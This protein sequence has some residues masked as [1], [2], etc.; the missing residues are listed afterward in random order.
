MYVFIIV[1]RV[2][3]WPV[4]GPVING[5]TFH[6]EINICRPLNYSSPVQ[7]KG[8]PKSSVCLVSDSSAVSYG[9][10]IEIENTSSY[11]IAAN[12]GTGFSLYVL[13][14]TLCKKDNEK[15]EKYRSHINFVCGPHLGAPELIL[16]N[17]CQVNFLWRTSAACAVKPT[18]QVP[19][20]VLD[21]NGNKRDLSPLIKKNE[22]YSV[23]TPN[24]AIDFIINVCSDI[25]ENS[26]ENK[27]PKNA[28]ACR[29]SG[30]ESYSFGSV[31]GGLKYTSEGLV[32]VYKTPDSAI[33]SPNCSLKPKTTI[34]FKCPARGY[35]QPPKLISDSNCQYE[36]E[37][38]TEYACPENLLKGNLKKC[39]F[40]RELHG[41]EID[42][43]PLREKHM[44]NV[45]VPGTSEYFLLSVCSGLEEGFKCGSKAWK[46][47]SVCF[48]NSNGSLQTA[49][50]T[51][52]AK[53]LYADG[54]VV[55]TYLKGESCNGTE[56]ST[57][58]NF[59][60]DK[61]A[62]NNGTGE[63]QHIASNDCSHIFEW[64]T[65]H[66]CL[67]HPLDA[68]CYVTFDK[69]TIDL[70]KKML[71]QGEPWEA[72][73]LRVLQPRSR[74]EYFIN[75]CGPIFNL[76]NFSMCGEGSSA[77]VLKDTGT[78]LNLGNFTSPPVYD[79]MSNSVWLH[80]TGG[81]PCG[82]NKFWHSSINFIC[83]PGQISSELILTR[84]NEVE[85]HYEFEWETADACP[86]TGFIEGSECR[87]I[88]N[89]FGINYDLNPLKSKVYKVTSPLYE[90]YLGVCEPVKDS[91]C[92]SKNVGVCQV[93]RSNK[94]AWKAGEPTSH[95]SYMDGV[96]NLMYMS[97]DP[98]YDQNHTSR[99]T[100]I[101]F[102]CDISAGNGNPH[103]IEEDDFAFVFH[104]Y[105]SLVCPQRV[106]TECIVHD[107]F[108]DVMYA[109]SDLSMPKKNWVTT[110]NEDNK[111][112]QIY[113]NV[114]RSLVLPTIGC[115]PNAAACLTEQ[116]ENGE[117]KVVV[118]NL[119][120][121]VNPPVLQSPGHL[122]LTYTD[123]DPCVSYGV[124]TTYRT[125]IHFLCADKDTLQTSFRFLSKVGACE[126]SF[127]W[128]TKAACPYGMASKDSCQLTDPDSGFTFDIMPLHQ[129]K[130]PYSIPSPSGGSFQL[131][132]CGKVTNG[133]FAS[134]GSQNETDKNVSV[135]EVDSKG[136]LLSN[137][138]TSDSFVLSYASKRELTL[139][140]KSA[141]GVS[142]EE[143]TIQFPCVN[144]TSLSDPKL[145]HAESGH[146]VFELKTP[147]ACI[148][149]PFDCNVVDGFGH[150]YDFTP[151][152]KYTGGN[153]EV[154]DF[155]PE[156][157]QLKYHINFC[158]PLNKVKSYKC[159]G[160]TSSACQTTYNNSEIIGYDLGS[161][162]V[163]PM[164]GSNGA[165]VFQYTD[166][167]YCLGGKLKR[168][169]TINLFCS[170]E[171]GDLKFLEET[172]ECEYIF[173]LDTPAAC[174]LQSSYGKNCI[175]KEPTFG[176][177]FNLNPLKNKNNNY[178]VTIG[179]YNYIFNVCDKI[180]GFSNKC[181]NSS[182]CQLKTKDPSFSKSLGLPSDALIY[183]KGVI[184]LEYKSGSS[185]CHGKYNR[186]TKIT[187]TCHHAHEDTDGPI[188]IAEAEDCTYLF[189]WP[190]VH[191][192]PPFDV[193][194]C[195]A[196][197][198]NG[199][200]YDL[201]RLSLPNENYY[202]KYPSA[203]KTF[204]INVCRSVVHTPNSLCPY[205]S[206]AC[207]ID[208]SSKLEPINL[209]TV[210]HAPYFDSGKIKI[211]YTSGDPCDEED[212]HSARFMQT[213]IEFS[214]DPS[215]I[216]SGPE[217]IGKDSC[218][219]Y[220]DW[221]TAYACPPK[222]IE[223]KDDCTV[224]DPITGYLFNF[225]SLG[226]HGVF[227]HTN[228][229]HQ[230]FLNV[231]GNDGTSPCGATVG[232]CQEEILGEKR[233]WSG[234]KLNRNLIYNNGVLLLNYTNGDSCHG[235]QFQ[236]N[237]LIEIH[238]GQGINE[239][240]FL[241]ESHNCTYVFSWKTELACQNHRHCAI[242]NGS[243]YYDL[244]PL[245]ESHHIAASAIINDNASYYI[246]VCNS[247]E[248]IAGVYCPPG[249]AI[250]RISRD[251]ATSSNIA[252]VSLFYYYCN[253]IVNV[254]S[255][256]LLS[257]MKC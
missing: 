60:C 247:L 7:Q 83:K 159:P 183:R 74:A 206:A 251:S 140:Y 179:E 41:A 181:A 160:G 147:L 46:S 51:N 19:C 35:S 110:I 68:P 52:S 248:E 209:G 256:K 192:C 138:A 242:K 211:N 172:P 245:A 18:N 161:Q 118:S 114:C 93:E 213:V 88:D 101:T 70:Q 176:Y 43:S 170:P 167:S 126:Y 53:L 6:Y 14:S 194:E 243:L 15:I 142:N 233:H 96:V 204:V 81:S 141:S 21:D 157:S 220:F 24:V 214:C 166:G 152:A 73:D 230:Y 65:T 104:W 202:V 119:G 240:Q 40:F 153:W 139:T 163:E 94:T 113:L 5:T 84:I 236:R 67:K 85:C 30:K 174:P 97:G 145:L 26:S 48:R 164:I 55:L 9:N 75:I 134:K 250:C 156:Y 246:S 77:C 27:C 4:S 29:I 231:C 173:S 129:V 162:M 89:D 112:R 91:P 122:I 131:N 90:F 13:T 223:S 116:D 10:A 168:S 255:T 8:C 232:M 98:Y 185:S 59:I 254:K 87:I 56:Q 215:L 128:A 234:G 36:V 144:S 150:E 49:G 165:V 20:Y 54:K 201:S 76:G 11:A 171:Q 158:R 197:D 238:C 235:G 123:G 257:Y 69:K 253:I 28:A 132:I 241:Y 175:V 50:T 31:S 2:S 135:C 177:T 187:F 72:I 212:E 154:S 208:S 47:T 203:N 32:L 226:S 63:P 23:Y 25:S 79:R 196:T 95:P 136:N 115:D 44:Y 149:E 38:E 217:F 106:L 71:V 39:Q 199:L 34:L 184:T 205:T 64:R 180:H 66:A 195:S 22:G 189:Q 133:C 111:E 182:A 244:M 227:K 127:L 92:T 1:F 137:I 125:L 252:E 218:T 37:W 151:L 33:L 146:Y 58:I 239:P 121:A 198:G 249:A 100:F 229:N 155:R 17:E 16:G 178:N 82:E 61:N 193:M 62:A 124:N 102:I 219:Y 207:L 45:T 80:Y 186:T 169:T 107:S 225:S 210:L 224:K 109:L 216:D 190:T 188:F 108:S 221:Q 3:S 12:M 228:G 57:V 103:F 99:I 191:A 130:E 117:E 237:T 120:R 105:T 200:Y 143:V 78:Y 222:E 42:L 148:P 86:V